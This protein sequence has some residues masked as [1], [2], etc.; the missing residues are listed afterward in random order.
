MEGSKD[1]AGKAVVIYSNN[2]TVTSPSNLSISN[3]AV[4]TTT[5]AK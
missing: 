4:Q 1:R 2:S 3:F 5:T